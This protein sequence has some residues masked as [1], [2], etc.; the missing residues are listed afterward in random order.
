MDA[1]TNI[2]KAYDIRGEVGTQ[3]NAQTVEQIARAYANWLPIKGTVAVGHDMRPDS[4]DLAQAFIKGLTDQGVDVWDIGEVTSDMIYFAVGNWDLAGGAVITASHNPGK[5]NGI[6]LYRDK[7]TAVGLDSGLSEIRDKFLAGDLGKP[8]DTPGTVEPHDITEDWINHALTFMDAD[9]TKEFRIAVDAGNGMAGKIFPELEPYVPWDVH[10]M[11][12]EL[13]GTFP[14]HEA[15]PMKPENMQDLVTKVKELKLDFG[16]AFDGDGDR[17]GFVDDTG[18]IVSGSSL[19]L[20]MAKHYLKKY[21]GATVV[22]DARMSHA[23]D[24]LVEKWG[25]K[26][27]VTPVGRVNV[28]TKMREI[29]AP[30][31]GE[32]TGHFYFVE[33]NDADSGLI[34]VLVAIQALS[35]SGKKLSQLVDEYRLYAMGPETNFVVADK[36]TTFA[37]LREAFKDGQ[38]T[39]LD[40]LSVDFADGSW[41]NVRASNTEPVMRLNAEAK[42]QGELDQLVA[43]VTKIIQGEQA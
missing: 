11:Y 36:A 26:T 20:I 35:D 7:V 24:E 1:I 17:A 12:F 42:T 23:I 18:R 21:P 19:M 41:F 6:K 25:G 14:N 22:R 2:F 32:E 9:K 28:G 3:L 4:K 15:N 38:Q 40:G 43:K 29:S 33:N 37:R 34:A 13:D 16:V 39:D 5:D 31:G 30:F 27:V 10:E 8:A